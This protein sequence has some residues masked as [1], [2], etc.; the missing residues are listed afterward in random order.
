[1]IEENPEADHPARVAGREYLRRQ[2]QRQESAEAWNGLGVTLAL[3]GRGGEA[4]EAFGRA[5]RL[6]PASAE[7][8]RNFERAARGAASGDAP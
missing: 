6:N 2:L 4:L 3:Q 1:M 5:V 8:R 7:Y